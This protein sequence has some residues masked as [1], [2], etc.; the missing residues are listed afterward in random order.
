MVLLT[1]CERLWIRSSNSCFTS[2]WLRDM[3][4][5]HVMSPM[6]LY[7]YLFLLCVDLS[8]WMYLSTQIY[9]CTQTQ[10]ETH[11]QTSV[12]LIDPFE[13]RVTKSFKIPQYW[14]GRGLTQ[15][16]KS[17]DRVRWIRSS[18]LCWISWWVHDQHGIHLMPTKNVHVCIVVCI[19]TSLYEYA[20]TH[21]HTHS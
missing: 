3:P 19:F 8:I 2:W 7:L 1:R 4:G 11:T 17:L 12:Q 6:Y 21:M 15:Q 18:N 13:W 20:Y 14:M 9:T 16:E 10:T 5:I